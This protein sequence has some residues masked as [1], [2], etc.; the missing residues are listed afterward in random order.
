M[1]SLL[2]HICVTRPQWIKASYIT[3][4]W[5][6]V[7]QLAQVNNTEYIRSQHYWP[8]VTDQRIPSTRGPV[9]RIAFPCDDAIMYCMQQGL[10]KGRHISCFDFSTE[11]PQW[12]TNGEIWLDWTAWWK[13][14]KGFWPGKGRTIFILFYFFRYGIIVFEKILLKK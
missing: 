11:T 14:L 2:T 9:T 1:V 7:Q 6:F 8:F 10:A 12:T 4:T 13:R 3:V 5:L